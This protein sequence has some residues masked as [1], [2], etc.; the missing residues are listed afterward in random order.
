MAGVHTTHVH[1]GVMFAYHGVV[2][3]KMWMS[4]HILHLVLAASW[5]IIDQNEVSL[6]LHVV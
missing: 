5:P 2:Q 4:R 6:L 1:V 3:D